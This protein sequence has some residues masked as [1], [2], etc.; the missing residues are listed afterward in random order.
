M[1][2]A[3]IK[4]MLAHKLRLFLTATSIA[5]GVAF[6]AG[7]LMLNDSM[8]RAFDDVFGSINSGTDVAVR[9]ESGE[10]KTADPDDS[11]PPVPAN[12][13]DLVR[14]VDGVATAEGSVRG[15][16]LLT[17][18]HGKPIQP[19]GAPTL[20]SNLASDPSLLGDITLRTGRAPQGP[21]EVA[22]DASSAKNGEL[23]VGSRTKILFRGSPET[24]TVVGTVGYAD[25]DDLGG[26][27]SAYF[28]LATAQRVLDKQGVYDSIAVKADDGISDT[29]LARRVDAALPQG[30][31]A[32]TGQAVAD[33]SSKAVKEGLG[34]LN[35]ALIGFAGIALFVGSFIIWNTFSMQVA[36]RTRELALFRAIGATRRQVMRTILAEAVVLGLAASG[37][38]ILLG[39]GMAK[40]LSALM[41]SFGFVLP[42]AALRIQPST[43]LV[44]FLV[45]TVVTI[46]AA[47]APARRATRVLPVEALRDAVPTAQRFSRVRLALGLVLST[48]GVGALLWGLFGSG[49]ALLIPGG[50]V[51]VVF[52]VTTL[53]PMIVLPMASV[54]GAP[55]K[56]QG[57]PGELARQNAM[58][59]PKR[60]AS[61]AM[62]LVIG[63]TLVSAVTVFG[64]SLKASFS[65]VLS[66]SVTADL[67]VLTP[68]P[69][70]AGF[71]PE[72]TE[73]V[74]DVEGVDVV[75]GSG[76]GTAKFDGKVEAFSSIDPQTADRAY[77]LGMVDAE[78]ADLTDGGVLVYEDTAKAKGWQV[79][80]VVDTA[81]ARQ[82]HAK[83]RVD[84]MYDDK[85]VVN[86]NY[87][88]SLGTHDR[89]VPDR[90]ESTDMVVV[91]KGA[92]VG[93]VEQRIDDALAAHPDAT[94]MDQEEFE[95]ALGG[96][97]DQL[98]SL[99]TVLLLLAVLI[100]LLG[101]INTLAL[102]VFERTREL[103][104]LRA[105]GMT[106][107]QVRA[108]VRWESVVISVI[109]AIIGAALG[110]GLGVALTRALADEGIEKIAVPGVQLAL[111]VLAAAVAGVLAAIGPARRASKVDVLRA[112]VTE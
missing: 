102:S 69:N 49:S 43:V 100:A 8:Q 35:I 74:K 84:G 98:L 13:L 48:A 83:L 3:T 106:R 6:L 87:V 88:I 50:V 46:V 57:L 5:L 90:L 85:S 1:L 28:D 21:G 31:Q 66:S 89:Y 81:F 67:Y 54:L 60:T 86:S 64:S 15:Y 107:G 77:D 110:I 71:S 2:S 72:V 47:V 82:G 53:A 44:G 30:M 20:G 26:S 24:F 52:G 109:G 103:G 23:S 73:V 51:G 55:L 25:E 39:L 58:R 56:S 18:A 99:V 36:Q 108:M 40:A 70:S 65:D 11:R 10:V 93:V 96:F 41:T 94:V 9:A 29:T 16:A 22:I 80:D 19:A 17:D 14:G 33:E 38:G 101:I 37:I 105:I 42:T 7:T 78:A 59:N 75:S 97:I 12:V 34:F 32:L 27:T 76:Y 112:V 45:G 92:D 91:D 79:G 104:L 68:S 62:A 95:G 111:Y 63:L 4:G 61:T